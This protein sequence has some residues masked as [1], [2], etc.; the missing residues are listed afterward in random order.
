MLLLKIF[1][2]VKKREHVMNRVIF[3]T[4]VGLLVGGAALLN[5][6]DNKVGSSLNEKYEIE[7]AAI[8]ESAMAA[9]LKFKPDFMAKEAEKEH[10]HGSHYLD[11]EGVDGKGNEVEFDML[12]KKG[13]WQIVEVQR[14]L[15]LAQCPQIVLDVLPTITP[16]RIIESDQTN[17]II[18]Y[19]FYTVAANGDESKFEVKVENNQAELLT[20]EW[21][22]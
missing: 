6:G 5:A 4:L 18:I 14:D 2:N 22:H 9:I 3:Y 1:V 17:G 15:S 8:P 7:L 11:I 12:Q 10:K 20:K 13:K 19:E 16:K 21:R